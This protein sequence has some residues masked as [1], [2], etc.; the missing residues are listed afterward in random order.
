MSEPG[1][2]YPSRS[3]MLQRAIEAAVFAVVALI[4]QQATLRADYA[5][6]LARAQAAEAT[7]LR[8]LRV[9]CEHAAADA[10]RPPQCPPEGAR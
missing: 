8:A 9:I 1:S 2:R 6:L 10:P 5:E 7:A 3:A 4:G